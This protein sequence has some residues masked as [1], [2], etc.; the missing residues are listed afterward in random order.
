MVSANIHYE[1]FFFTVNI[2]HE[3]VSEACE[4]ALGE[5]CGACVVKVDS[6]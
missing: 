5:Q 3:V 1:V 4:L 2:F 6:S